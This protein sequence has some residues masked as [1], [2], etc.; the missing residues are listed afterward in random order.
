MTH[1]IAVGSLLAVG[2]GLALLAGHRRWAPP[3]WVAL[4]VGAGLRLAVLHLSANDTWQPWDFGYHFVYTADDIRVGRDP[5]LHPDTGWH[6]L[7]PMAYLLGL[8]RALALH[9]DIPWAITGRTVPMLADLVLIVL[10]GKLA[11]RPATAPATN[12]EAGPEPEAGAEANREALRRFQYACM[13]VAMLVGTLHA[14]ITPVALV[15]C[16]AMLLAMRAGRPAVAGAMLGMA[17]STGNWPMVLL[18]ALLL[19]LRG[20]RSRLVATAGALAVP[21]AWLL[22]API[23][24]DSTFADLPALARGVLATRPLIGEWGWTVLITG[25]DLTDGPGVARVGSL[26]LLGGFAAGLV[27]WRHA[28]PTDVTIVILLVFLLVTYRFGSQYLLW[29]VPFLVARPTRGTW[30]ML[31]ATAVWCAVG[32]LWLTRLTH[33]DWVIAHRWWALTSLALLPLV[34]WALP[35]ARRRARAAGERTAERPTLETARTAV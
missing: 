14:Q 10:V 8:Q 18:P 27:W 7:P 26:L 11:A 23:F 1:T 6:F 29:S 13:P 4:A 5:L 2:L 32:Y 22:T 31:A 35:W 21:G 28:D 30:P 12:S 34:A 16:V 9:L 20:L 15:F 25:G 19:G 24:L 33:G 3:L 17:A